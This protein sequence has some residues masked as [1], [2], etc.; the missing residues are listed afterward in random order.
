MLVHSKSF[1]SELLPAGTLIPPVRFL[2]TIIVQV[3]LSIGNICMGSS[4]RK[5]GAGGLDCTKDA[6]IIV[7]R[8]T[9]FEIGSRL[10][11][12]DARK[13]INWVVAVNRFLRMITFY[14]VSNLSPGG[15]IEIFTGLLSR[16]SKASEYE[17]NC[18]L[19]LRSACHRR[20]LLRANGP[21]E[22]AS[23]DDVIISTF[24]SFI[25]LCI[26]GQLS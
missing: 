22:E 3:N 11:K 20:R 26:D 14:G 13:R 7:D 24:C 10:R 18:A 19:W 23:N 5:S 2:E 6:G 9:S 1:E 8:T 25:V 15:E 4:I 17:T 21:V 16:L 12:D